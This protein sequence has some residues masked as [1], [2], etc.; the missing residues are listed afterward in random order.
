MTQNHNEMLNFIAM[1]FGFTM[2]TILFFTSSQISV[3]DRQASLG[4]KT[5]GW[6]LDEKLEVLLRE[7]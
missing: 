5:T 3:G 1:V 2:I 6:A 4:V 7:S